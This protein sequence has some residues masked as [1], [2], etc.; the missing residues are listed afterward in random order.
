LSQLFRSKAQSRLLEYLLT[1]KGRVFNQAS[2]AKFL[3]V[4]PTTVARVMGPLIAEGIVLFERYERGMKMFCL[5]E[6]NE[7][8]RLLIDFHEKLKEL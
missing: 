3:D 1:N 7:K 8:A 2:L 5:N 4:S 6:E